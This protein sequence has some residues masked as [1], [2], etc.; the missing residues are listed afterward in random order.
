MIEELKEELQKLADEALYKSLMDTDIKL[1][2]RNHVYLEVLQLI[3]E[4]Q[5]KHRI[6]DVWKQQTLSR[7]ERVV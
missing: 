5:T 4:L 2:V 1:G 7:F 3:H 6:S